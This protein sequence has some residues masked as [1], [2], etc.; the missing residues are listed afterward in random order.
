[1]LRRYLNHFRVWL[2][3]DIN[4]VF[5]GTTFD[6]RGS[7]IFLQIYIKLHHHNIVKIDSIPRSFCHRHY[8]QNGLSYSDEETWLTLCLKRRQARD[9]T[10]SLLEQIK[11]SYYT[12]YKAFGP[13]LIYNNN[14][15]LIINRKLNKRWRITYIVISSYINHLTTIISGNLFY[16]WY[17]RTGFSLFY[18]TWFP[19][20]KLLTL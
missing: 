11:I 7:E 13:S 3:K 17:K 15:T 9:L 4:T 1:M 14:M 12:A 16:S 6:I 10:S 20:L 18:A 19:S 5:E 8:V 2:I